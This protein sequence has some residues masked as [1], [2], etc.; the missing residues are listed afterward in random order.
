M[1][2]IEK[3]A[4]VTSPAPSHTVDTGNA[5]QITLDI[6]NRLFGAALP[7][8]AA[9]QLWDGARWPESAPEDVATTVVLNHPGALRRMFL[10]PTE[11]S[12]GEAFIRGDFDIIGDL[13]AACGLNDLVGAARR[14]PTGMRRAC[15]G[16]SIPISGTARQFSITTM[17]LMSSTRSGWTNG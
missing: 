8:T 12:L 14:S 3:E 10:P 6:L 13:E 11:L 5:R 7:R 9:I 2:T 4:P 16:G 1:V 15:M 17:S